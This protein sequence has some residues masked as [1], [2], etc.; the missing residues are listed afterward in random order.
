MNKTSFLKFFLPARCILFLLI[1]AVGALITG[2][3]FSGISCWWSIVASA[4]NILTILFLV[5]SAKKG[6][7]SYRGLIAYEKGKTPLKKTI[8]LII[9]F[10][11]IGMAGLYGAGY[12]CYGVL[13]YSPPMTLEPIPLILAILNIAVLPVTTALAE[14]GLYLGGGVNQIKNKF[15]AIILPAFFYALQHCFIPPLFDAKYMI[16]RFI[17]FLPLTVIF[18]IQYYKKRDP[19]PIMISHAILDLATAMTIVAT[20]ADH[21]LY[22]N[23]INM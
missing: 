22:E 16:Y 7:S 17:S 23:M 21:S 14:D 1:F 4:V 3:E 19:L 6:G 20:S 11:F 13:P 5:I 9:G 15:T 12:I 8:L 2:K 10:I 18:C